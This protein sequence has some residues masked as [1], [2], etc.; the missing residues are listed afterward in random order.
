MK[1]L[2]PIFSSIL[3]VTFLVACGSSPKPEPAAPAA[4]TAPSDGAA[5]AGEELPPDAAASGDCGGMTGKACA[6]GQFCLY[7]IEAT[8]GAADQ[9]GTC[10]KVPEAC[11]MDYNPVCGC[12]DKTYP[13]AC[14]AHSK[15]VSV[16]R[17]GECAG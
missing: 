10:T 13:N 11:T 17:E 8:C 15:G 1:D 2:R 6:E 16:A 9:M 5:P 4:E 7:S 12:D 14:G 3:P